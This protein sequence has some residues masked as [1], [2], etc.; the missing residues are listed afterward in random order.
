M[1]RAAADLNVLSAKSWPTLASSDP[2]TIQ[3]WATKN[4]GC[5]WAM[6][7]GP[8]SGLF[9]LDV[10]GEKGR[11]SL[12]ILEAKHGPLP[13][14]LTSHTGREDGGEQR[15]FAWPGD[16][17][18]RSSTGKLGVGLDIRA[19]GGYV[20]VPPSIHPTGRKYLWVDHD[21]TIADAPPSLLEAIATPQRFVPTPLTEI[22]ILPTGQRNDGLTR[23]GGALRRKGSTQS[24]I[25]TRLLEDNLRRCR[26]PLESTEVFKI[27]ASVSRY[28]PSSGALP[29]GTHGNRHHPC[30]ARRSTS[31]KGSTW[32]ARVI[33]QA[34]RVFQDPG[35]RSAA[36]GSRNRRYSRV[37]L[38]PL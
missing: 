4:P 5:N 25:E 38:L 1:V 20:I 31:A 29:F 30:A 16:R 18:I 35:K 13:G 8:E 19:A 22:G 14:T 2:A 17:N 36:S 7:C 3:K 9:V 28:E 12:E 37:P 33:G 15:Y 23:L 32:R 27:A 34:P 21:M 6:A 26:P 11:L 10:D 24:E